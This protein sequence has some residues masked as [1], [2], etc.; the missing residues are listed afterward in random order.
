MIANHT[1]APF[2]A[3]LS[4]VEIAT[5]QK[6]PPSVTVKVYHQD[7]DEAATE[8]LRLYADVVANVQRYIEAAA[9]DSE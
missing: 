7:P 5:R 1:V 6:G 4:S 3:P 8:A 2:D 9:A